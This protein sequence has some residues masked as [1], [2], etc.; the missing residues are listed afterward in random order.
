VTSIHRRLFLQGAGDCGVWFEGL[1]ARLMYLSLYKIYEIA[2][3]GV[4]AVLLDALARPDYAP[5]QAD[6]TALSSL[7]TGTMVFNDI[8]RAFDLAKYV[9]ATEP[10]RAG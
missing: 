10:A 1:F 8:V 9:S 2:L 6:E 3:H 7:R 4:P 5:H